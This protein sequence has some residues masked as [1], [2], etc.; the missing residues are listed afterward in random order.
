MHCSAGVGRTGTLIAL[1]TLLQELEEGQEEVN[2]FET[3]RR[4]RRSRPSMVQSLVCAG[5]SVGS[6]LVVVVSARSE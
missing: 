3:V 4:M 5:L 1:D 6:L 2:V